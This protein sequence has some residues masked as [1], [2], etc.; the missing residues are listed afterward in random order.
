MCQYGTILIKSAVK[1]PTMLEEFREIQT[2]FIKG[3]RDDGI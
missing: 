2:Q 1:L 3:T